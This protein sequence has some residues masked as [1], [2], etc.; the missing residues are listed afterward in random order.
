MKGSQTLS[1][2]PQGGIVCLTWAGDCLG[3]ELQK[4]QARCILKGARG[5]LRCRREA[6]ADPGKGQRSE[7]RPYRAGA[8][9]GRC[10]RGLG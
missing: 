5:H 9:G 10:S 4:R 1:A 6:A 8:A 3:K 7:R 2:E